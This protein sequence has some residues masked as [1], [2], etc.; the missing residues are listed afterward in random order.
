MA[1]VGAEGSPVFSAVSG[2]A[3][4]LSQLL[5]CIS[6]APMAHVQ[7]SEAGLRVMVEES[8]VMQGRSRFH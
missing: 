8:R 4:Q 2:S 7:I 3:R 6:F 1:L 5:R